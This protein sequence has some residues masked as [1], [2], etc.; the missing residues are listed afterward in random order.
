MLALIGVS[1]GITESSRLVAIVCRRLR[2]M[3]PASSRRAMP[4][5]KSRVLAWTRGRFV[6]L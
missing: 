3:V 1:A 2:V 5:A 4:F 6:F